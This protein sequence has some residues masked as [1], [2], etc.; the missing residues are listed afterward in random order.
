LVVGFKL[1]DFLQL[2]FFLHFEQ[3]LLHGL[4]QKHVQDRLHFAV[5]VEQVVVLDLGYLVDARLL[6]HVLRGLGTRLKCVGLAFDILLYRLRL[7][8]LGQEVGQVHF[9]AA[10]GAGPEVV[11]RGLV[12]L[13]LVDQQLG[14]DH[15]DLLFFLLF[16]D[17]EIV[18]L[19]GGH[20]CLEEVHVV[21]VASEDAFVVHDVEGLAL[22]LLWLLEEA[23]RLGVFVLG[24][25]A[26]H[27]GLSTFESL[28]G[29]F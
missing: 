9:D 14:L 12:F 7:V 23:V 24:L 2:S 13:L 21:G 8:L 1:P 20:V 16:F 26:E 6:G 11:G 4:G 29:H 3:G 25:A 28:V 27:L 19:L 5:E 18:L 17:S 22:V 10:R 15:F